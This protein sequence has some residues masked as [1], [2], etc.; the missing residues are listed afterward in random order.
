[1]KHIEKINEEFTNLTFSEKIAKIKSN[2]PGKFDHL[3]DPK[4]INALSNWTEEEILEFEKKLKSKSIENSKDSEEK[5][6]KNR[7]K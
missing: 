1:M 6:L 5:L 3:P 4:P 7:K 2:N